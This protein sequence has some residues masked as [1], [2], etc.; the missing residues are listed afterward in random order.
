MNT[1]LVVNEK[2]KRKRSD[3]GVELVFLP[4]GNFLFELNE[5]ASQVLEHFRDPSL[6]NDVVDVIAGDFEPEDASDIHSDIC[7]LVER[8]QQHGILVVAAP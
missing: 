3:A 5:T 1:L 7:I 2:A 8:F 6:V 4:G